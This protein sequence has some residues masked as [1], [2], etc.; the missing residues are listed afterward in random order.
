MCVVGCGLGIGH[1][2]M[3][4]EQLWNDAG[5]SQ[6]IQRHGIRALEGETKHYV[7]LRKDVGTYFEVVAHPESFKSV[8]LSQLQFSLPSSLGT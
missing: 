5:D 2:G 8:D 1:C 7:T 4:R 6:H 3:W